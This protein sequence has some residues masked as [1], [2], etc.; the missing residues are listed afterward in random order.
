M[1]FFF[2]R[3]KGRV[4]ELRGE[5]E[6]VY[7]RSNLDAKLLVFLIFH[8]FSETKKD[9]IVRLNSLLENRSTLRFGLEHL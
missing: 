7:L 6:V 1:C 2:G 3:W 5:W 8:S 4:D 9:H